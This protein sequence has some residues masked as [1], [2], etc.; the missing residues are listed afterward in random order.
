MFNET[1]YRPTRAV[2]N[3][4]AIEQNAQHLIS[5]LPKE[6][7][8]IAVVKS[9]G[10]GHGVAQ[11][12]S[13]ALQAGADM[14]AVATPD[15][16]MT[17]R[18]T[19]PTTDIL[20]L[21]FSP[22]SFAAVAA[23]HRIIL[24]VTS[25]NWVKQVR[26][27]QPFDNKCRI[28]VK[29]DSGMGRIGVRTEEE[30]TRLAKSIQQ[31]DLS[32]DGVFTH[33]ARADEENREPTQRQ[34][35]RFMRLVSCLPEKPRLIHASNSAGILLFPEYALDAVRFGISL[36]GI[37][38]SHIVAKQL[39]FKLERALTIETELTY[40]KQ[41]AAGEEISYGGTYKAAEGEW[42]G[43]LPVG[44][45][46]GLRRSLRGQEVLIDGKR[47]PI[48]GTICMD[49][50]MIRLPRE[51]PEG[52]KVILIGKQGN[53]EIMIEEWSERLNT[54]PYEVAVTISTRIPRVYT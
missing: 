24:T 26:A 37:P 22:V 30:L 6:T 18:K 40:V 44:Y 12:A 8:L 1:Q 52:E 47:V 20:V 11:A 15:E 13:A 54:I 46:D 9:D 21:G 3:T 53:E 2:I 19:Q 14:F 32:I 31:S 48:V 42:I 28:H 7:K 50:C 10:Y 5:Y 51:Y 17:L 33:F 4:A 36:Y 39:P 16:A 43:T 25:E 27:Q 35:E 45:A 34:F 29:I 23:K 38:P 49:Q 41:M